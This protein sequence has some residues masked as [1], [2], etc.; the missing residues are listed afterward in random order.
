MQ[1]E[2]HK[3]LNFRM[4]N[5]ILSGRKKTTFCQNKPD[6]VIL[7]NDTVRQVVSF[8]IFSQAIA[9]GTISTLN[10][11]VFVSSAGKANLKRYLC[12][13][14]PYAGQ[15]RDL[16]SKTILMHDIAHTVTENCTESPLARLYSRKLKD[17]G[18]FI[19]IHEYEAGGRLRRD[20]EKAG[21]Q[22][23]LSA[24]WGEGVSSG[25]TSRAGNHAGEISDMAI[26]ARKRLEKA[27]DIVGPELAGVVLDVCCFLK[28]FELVERERQWPSRSAKLMLKTALSNLARHYGLVPT[29]AFSTSHNPR[30]IQ[31]WGTNDYRPRL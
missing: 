19:S 17:G 14:D 28:G 26:D 11:S 29:T 18:R 3:K 1:H 8:E 20:F 22:A 2:K 13:H 4:L 21:L 12:D 24:N 31:Q 15:H 16:A 7:I 27:M 23:S 6:Q 30:D 5:F 9:S 25:N 10:N